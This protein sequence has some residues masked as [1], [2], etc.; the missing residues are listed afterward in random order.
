METRGL[1]EWGVGWG[2][3]IQSRKF[4]YKKLDVMQPKLKNRS[5]LPLPAGEKTILDQSK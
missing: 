4:K 3:L 1:F 2:V 5:E